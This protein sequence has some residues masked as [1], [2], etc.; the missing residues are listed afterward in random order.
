MEHIFKQG[1][2]E[3]PTFILLHGTGGDENDL[4]PLAAA[5]NADYSVLSIRGEVS[6]NGMN[7]F[8]KRH[9]EGQYDVDDLKYR[10]TRLAAFIKE[11]AEKYGFDVE[12]SIP[13]GFSNGSNIAISMILNESI[14]FK[15]AL[16]YAPLYPLNITEDKDLS[17][18][19][20]LLSMGERDPIVTMDA[21]KHV[22][23][24]FKQTGANITEVWVN[25]HELTQ[26]GV[27]AGQKVIMN[28]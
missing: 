26:A 8:F 21:S 13:V 1:K 15:A 5:L 3:A 10:T 7:R 2:P 6:E 18:M 28:S 14:T 9:G 22:I 24:L 12:Q 27:I 4:M 19:N 20:V 23:E 11:A 16:L 17:H 25:S